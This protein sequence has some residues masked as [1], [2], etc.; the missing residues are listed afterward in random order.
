MI[1]S[2]ME[3]S[4]SVWLSI[5]WTHFT[6]EIPKNFV[7]PLHGARFYAILHIYR[8][9]YCFST[10]EWLFI[11]KRVEEVRLPVEIR[12]ERE[13]NWLRAVSVGS[14]SHFTLGAGEDP[15]GSVI[16]ESSAGTVCT[17]IWVVPRSAQPRPNFGDGDFFMEKDVTV[18]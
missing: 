1:E 18:R 3:Q 9:E 2:T 16:P 4:P 13:S 7:Y 14:V 15:G 17:G 10:D 6:K 8:P 11:K 5:V 12:T